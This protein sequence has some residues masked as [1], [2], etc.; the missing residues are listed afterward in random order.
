MLTKCVLCSNCS[1]IIDCW[2]APARKSF[3]TACR[4]SNSR[5]NG[6]TG[7]HW[8]NINALWMRLETCL[9]FS[10]GFAGALK[11]SSRKVK[12]SAKLES[13]WHENYCFSKLALSF[14]Q[15]SVSQTVSRINSISRYVIFAFLLIMKTYGV[16]RIADLL[17]S[18][19]FR[20]IKTVVI[21]WT[22]VRACIRHVCLKSV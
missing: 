18:Y 7:K 4:C 10:L 17:L 2:L 16:L 13:Q 3:A 11:N 6:K 9:F 15:N 1:Q 12:A 22:T 5:F 20:H 14:S 21:V 19:Y 8:W